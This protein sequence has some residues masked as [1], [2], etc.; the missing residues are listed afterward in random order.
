VKVHEQLPPDR[1][2]VLVA[3][4]TATINR[5]R[6]RFHELDLERAPEPASLDR[7]KHREV[8]R[9]WL[10]TVPGLVAE[11]ARVVFHHLHIDGQ[12]RQ[13]PCQPAAA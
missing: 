1:R 11:L 12:N 2:E 10:D 7:A 4:R 13:Q 6:W 8:L 9:I 3:Q 5:L